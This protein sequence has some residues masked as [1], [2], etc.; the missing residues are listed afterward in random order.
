MNT[1]T[2]YPKMPERLRYPIYPIAWSLQEHLRYWSA[3][4]EASASAARDAERQLA[5]MYGASRVLLTDSGRAALV[6]AMRALGI[7]AGSEV[8]MATY[9]CP[10]VIDAVL[11]VGAEPVLVDIDEG[12]AVSLASVRQHAGPRTAALLLTHCYGTNERTELIDWARERGIAVIDDAAQAMFKTQQGRL[13]GSLGD[14]GVLSFGG[15]K[16]LFALGGG[17]LLWYGDPAVVDDLEEQIPVE[18]EAEV[19]GMY[20]AYWYE[21]RMNFL[22]SSP[23]RKAKADWQLRG[24]VPVWKEDKCDTLPDR[25]E[26]ITPHRMHGVKAALLQVQLQKFERL[27]SWTMHNYLLLH[28]ELSGVPGVQLVGEAD[29]EHGYNYVTLVF[30]QPG[31]R[32]ACSRHLAAQGIQTA[33]NYYPL[34]LI[35]I[36]QQY[37]RSTSVANQLWT[38]VLSL[39]FKPKYKEQDLRNIANA[40]RSFHLNEKEWLS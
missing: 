25:H 13:A 9:N 28:R 8:L 4:R 34:H 2:L 6:L 31:I 33:W 26:Q 38:R 23:L 24:W 29:G 10:A 17:A 7:G 39:P 35:P 37:G 12:F 40:V 22:L 5:A 18:P 36:Y 32:Y 21:Q 27:K 3:L 19:T 14:A 20:E 16:P 15:T 1:D 11:T 30:E